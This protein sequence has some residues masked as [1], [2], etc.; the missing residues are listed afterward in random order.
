MCTLTK[1]ANTL[2]RHKEIEHVYRAIK[3]YEFKASGCGDIPCVSSEAFHLS[4]FP[5]IK[6]APLLKI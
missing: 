5:E 3:N 4:I 2:T 6:Q 1:I